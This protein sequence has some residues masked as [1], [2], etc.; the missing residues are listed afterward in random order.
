MVTYSSVYDVQQMK[1]VNI[2]ERLTICA[3]RPHLV[4]IHCLQV[5]AR[6]LHAEFTN[7]SV[8]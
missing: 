8:V 6:S 1:D 4:P 5:S 7:D 2:S 3:N